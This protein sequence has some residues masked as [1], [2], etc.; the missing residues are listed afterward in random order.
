MKR[1]TISHD[2]RIELKEASL[3]T[4]PARLAVLGLLEKTNNPVDVATIIDNLKHKDIKADP[5]TVFRT[6]NLFTDKGIARQIQFYEGKFRYELSSRKDHHHLVC[7]N[8][9]V[10]EDISDC[11]IKSLEKEIEKRKNFVVQSHSL[12]FF[13]VCPA[14]QR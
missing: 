7:Q 8:C 12:E 13:G 9:G 11:N 2:C 10:I 14:C 6:I 5:A 3:K 4:T 1:P